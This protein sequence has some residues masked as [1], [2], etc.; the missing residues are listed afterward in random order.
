MDTYANADVEILA[1][2]YTKFLTVVAFG[3]GM[4]RRMKTLRDN[5]DSK[6]TNDNTKQMNC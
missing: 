2:K 3:N 1:G 4:C 6:F 5:K